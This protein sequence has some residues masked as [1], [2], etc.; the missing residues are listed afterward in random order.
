VLLLLLRRGGGVDTCCCCRW[1]WPCGSS[2][3]GELCGGG[4][5]PDCSMARALGPI[6]MAATGAGGRPIG[7]R[8]DVGGGGV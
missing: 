2:G 3:G 6:S 7:E 1:F 8:D 4:G 5:C